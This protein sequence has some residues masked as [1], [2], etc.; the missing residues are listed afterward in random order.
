M[1]EFMDGALAEV[2]SCK[3]PKEANAKFIS[4]LKL[5]SEK[6][7]EEFLNHISIIINEISQDMV[8]VISSRKFCDELISC[9]NNVTDDNLAVNAFQAI[10]QRMQFRNIAFESQLVD[11]RDRLS[12][13]LEAVGSL[14]EAATVLS[15]IP[16]ES[17]QRTYPNAFKMEIYLRIAE[18]YLQL[19]EIGEAEAYVN[20]ASLLQPDCQDQQLLLR[21]KTAY[22][23]LLDH[24]HKFLEAGQRYAELS[25]RFQWMDESERVAFLERALAAVFLA[26]AGHQRTRLLATLY[27]DERCQ[28]FD[29]YPVLEKM[30]MGRLINRSSLRSLDPLFEKFYPHL[31]Q[32]LNVP[33]ESSTP[34]KSVGQA[35]SVEGLLERAVVEHNMV[36]ASL[37]YNN[38]SLVNLGALLEISP[39]EAESIASQM[40][41]E[42]RLSGQIDQIDNVIHFKSQD[43]VLASWSTQVNSLC[44]AVNRIVEDMEAAHP[45]WVHAQLNARMAV[46]PAI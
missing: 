26:G 15:E 46:D 10:L 2:L 43:P 13:R 16:L 35:Q 37:I 38:I 6:T 27:K 31:L 33:S 24:K 14:R 28:A 29:A 39:S 17:G 11:L 22:A 1:A 3:V 45:D 32:N 12:K 41:S 7:G 4:L 20:R 25:I 18:Y 42:D 5:V 36:A 9:V 40:I 34:V 23:H 8:A 44:A 19:R 30:Y 21:Y